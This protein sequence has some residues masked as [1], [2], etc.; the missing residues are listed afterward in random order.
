M[1]TSY[2]SKQAQEEVYEMRY[3]VHLVDGAQLIS[4]FK[5][6]SRIWKDRT[7]PDWINSFLEFMQE[8]YP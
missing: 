5:R 4:M 3:P 2:F 8:G 7:D 1:T 6:S